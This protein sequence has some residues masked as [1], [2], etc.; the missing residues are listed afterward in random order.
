MLLFARRELHWLIL[1]RNGMSVAH[2]CK[3]LKKEDL[4]EEGRIRR[5]AKERVAF[6]NWNLPEGVVCS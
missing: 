5:E 2:F 6:P 4:T 1:F 3:R